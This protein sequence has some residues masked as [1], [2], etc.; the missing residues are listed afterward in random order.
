M[1]Y[2]R[3]ITLGLGSLPIMITGLSRNTVRDCVISVGDNLKK[4]KNV[5]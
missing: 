3:L 5:I 2:S 4:K 1:R